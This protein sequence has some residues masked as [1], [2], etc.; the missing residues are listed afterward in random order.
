MKEKIYNQLKQEYARL[1]LSD[2]LLQ[3]VA[4]SLEATGL[5]TDENLATVVKG[6]ENM[7]KSYQSNFD[8]L[9]TEGAGYKKELEELKA[10]GGGQGGGQQQQPKN[11]MPEWF[12]KYKDEQDKKLNAL[13]EENT[14]FKAEKAKGERNALILAKAKELKISKS[15]IEEGFAIPDDMDEAGIA[16]YL[17]KVKKNE[18]A[19]G[20]EDRSS[21]FSLSTSED[22]GKELA[23]EWAKSLPDA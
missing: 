18:V 14:K 3:S 13:I 8:K 10:K 15:R 11:E 2:E 5:V 21:A 7:L 20:L 1:G 17:S 23:K 19:K 9:R 12:T 4:A 6:Q 16:T 22:Q